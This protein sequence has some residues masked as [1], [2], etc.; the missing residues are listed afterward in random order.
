[1]GLLHVKLPVACEKLAI[2]SGATEVCFM[3]LL[4]RG[5]FSM[6]PEV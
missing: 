6:Q 1:M 5:A 4:Q 3:R 2:L